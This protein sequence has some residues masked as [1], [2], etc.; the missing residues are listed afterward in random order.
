MHKDI[1]IFYNSGKNMI[2]CSWISSTFGVVSLVVWGFFIYIY[3]T[4]LSG[5]L[6]LNPRTK[7]KELTPNVFH[8]IILDLKKSVISVITPN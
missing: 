7:K 4:K 2:N 1:T 8:F 6:Y 5:S 3:R